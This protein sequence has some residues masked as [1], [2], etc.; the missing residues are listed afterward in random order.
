MNSKDIIIYDPHGRKIREHIFSSSDVRRFSLMNED[1]I[2]LR[3][4]SRNALRFAVGSRAGDFYITKEHPAKWNE[5][6]G[7]WDYELKFDAYY[8]LWGNK[9]LRYV[10][11]GF[12]SARE[13][14]FTLTA[15]IDLHANVILNCLNLLGIKYEGSPFRVETSDP[16]LGNEA[17]MVRYENLSILGG[18]QAIAEA[19]DC[20]WWVD[21]NAIYFGR[22]ENKGSKHVFED[23]INTST[24]SFQNGATEVPNRLY[25]YGSDRNLPPNYRHTDGA[26]TIGGVVLRRLM[27]PDGVPYLQTRTDLAESEVVEKVVVLDSVYPR[28]DLTVDGDPETYESRGEDSEGNATSETYY[29]LRYNP[30]F[31]FSESYVLPQEELHLIFQSGMLNGMEFGARF[32]PKGLPEKNADGSWNQAAQMIEVVVNEDYG[33]RL[34]DDILRPVAGDKFILVGWDTTKMEELGLIAS[35]EEELLEEGKKALEEYSK[36]LS[37]C[38]CPMAWEY[39]KPLF[40]TNSE[41]KPGDVVTIIDTAH[42]GEGGR[43]SRIIGYEYKLDKPY[44]ECVYTCGENVA[45]R[46]LESLEKKIEGLAKSGTKVQ[47]Q[48]SL[49]FLSKRYADRTPYQLSSDTGFEVGKYIAGAQGAMLGKDAETGQTFGE[50]DRL[51][52]R[53]KA[54]FESLTVIEAGTLAGKQYITP[55]GAV[56]ITGVEKVWDETNH[57]D[58]LRCF[59]LSEQDGEKRDCKFIAQDQAI[60]Q[61]FNIREGDHS[62]VSSRYYWRV[63]EDVVNDAFTDENTGNHYGYVDLSVTRCDEGSDEPSEGD[64]LVQFGSRAKGK[65][66]RQ[67]AMVFSTVDADSPSVKLFSGID[68]FSLEDKAIISFGRDPLN[69]QVYFRL[70]NSA[71]KEY[72]HYTQKGGLEV[73]GKINVKSTIGDKPLDEYF[74]K[75][76]T[77]ETDRYKYLAQ[78]LEKAVKDSTEIHGGLLLTTMISLGYTEGETRRILSGM[79]GSYNTELGGRTPAAWYGGEMIDLF[80]RFDTRRTEKGVN[81]AKSMIRMDGSAYFSNGNIG[82]KADGGGWLGNQTDGIIFDSDGRI[83]FGNGIKININDGEKGLKET[84]ESLANFMTNFFMPEDVNGKPAK[85]SDPKSVDRIKVMRSLYTDGFLSAR[86][87]NPFATDIP[88]GLDEKRL[89]EYL[90]E[91]GYVKRVD[92]P[93]LT[94]YATE[95]WV[96]D[97]NYLTSSALTPYLKS[98]EAAKLYQSKGDYLTEHQ[99]I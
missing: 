33:R 35:A 98:E 39:M 82:F 7:A 96:T 73:A 17:K 20:E 16:E 86:G 74:G 6:T 1:S 93:S 67:S 51:F 43:K 26:D 52:V 29:R 46:R 34:P 72:L 71:A 47:M 66:E 27:L 64:V 38:T 15:T 10:I 78:S 63:V 36:D 40:A 25:M 2:T 48:N 4:S 24:I 70:G 68:S 57:R 22:C 13:T 60:C 91:N 21:G 84:L 87:I 55:G 23:G 32:N 59:F 31:H 54:Y 14:T 92:L 88:V 97:Q 30:D 12:D 69:N 28:T 37:T 44:A 77:D 50:M 5:A 11:P 99:N 41:P 94:G 19:F 45:V 3:F 81:F 49:D 75:I 80:D 95:K 8:W 9:I 61:Q 65:A 62:Q 90:V 18:I 53:V 42:F 58:L 76:V 79:N 83:S 89:G 56:K 85:W